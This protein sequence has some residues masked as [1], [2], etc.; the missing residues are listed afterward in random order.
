LVAAL[1]PLGA[2]RK[3][4]WGIRR[5]HG[6]PSGCCQDPLEDVRDEPSLDP[7]EAVIG[8]GIDPVGHL[9]TVASHELDRD[10]V[11]RLD[12][13]CGILGAM[14]HEDGDVTQSEEIIEGSMPEVAGP[15]PLG[16]TLPLL[17]ALGILQYGTHLG[18][19]RCDLPLPLRWSEVG[20]MPTCEHYRI[21]HL[22]AAPSGQEHEMT[23]AGWSEEHGRCRRHI[24][25]LRMTDEDHPA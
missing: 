8:A 14:A 25:A 24:R 10:E 15:A 12:R 7:R 6:G 4:A 3:S 19:Q 13:D 2:L 22:A 21:E 23:D 5:G 20:V 11:G 9:A 16:F 18:A 1:V 17:H